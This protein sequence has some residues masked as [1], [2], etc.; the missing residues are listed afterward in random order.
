MASDSFSSSLA[1]S[2]SLVKVPSKKHIWISPSVV[3]TT[4]KSQKIF[5]NKP[6]N[7]L[8]FSALTTFTITTT[9]TASQMAMKAKN[10]KKQQQAVTTAMVT[11]NPFVVSDKIFGK[12][13]IAAVSF[14]T[15]MDGN[16]S[17]TSSKMG[18]IYHWLCYAV[19]LFYIEFVFQKSLNSVIK[20]AIGNESSG[21]VFFSSPFLLVAFCNVLL[22]TSFDNIKS[23]LGIFSVVISVKLKPAGLWQYVVVYFKDTFFAVAA[24]IHWSVLVRKDSIRIFPV[25]NQNDVISSRDAFKAKLVN[26]LFNCTAFKISNLVSQLPFFSSKF[27]SNTFGGPK[28]F[29]LLFAESKSYAKAAVFVV[30]FVAAAINMN[31]NLSCPPK[32]TTLM[33]SVVLSA[34]NIVVE[35]RLAF[36]ESHLSKLSLLIKSLVEPIGILAVLV[37]KL[38]STLSIMD[39]SVK[40]SVTGLAKQNKGL[41]AVAFMM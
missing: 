22:G 24:L 9:I 6:V 32:T 34:S 37:T 39:V 2:S 1:S 5:N 36:L 14:F 19:K 15:D 41:A 35:S 3:F 10:S 11:P 28:V 40:K 12:I 26:F 25:V 17:G 16:S 7:K 23:A 33:M 21:V 31:L 13:F 38:L 18:K 4:S 30:S 8:V 27:F 20:V 29:K